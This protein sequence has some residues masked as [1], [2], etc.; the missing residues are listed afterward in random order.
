M[1]SPSMDPGCAL[2]VAIDQPTICLEGV[3]DGGEVQP[4]RAG[5]QVGDVGDRQDVRSVRSEPAT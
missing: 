2:C 4:A 3:L 5:A 1:L